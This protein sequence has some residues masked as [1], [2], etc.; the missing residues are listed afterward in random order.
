MKKHQLNSTEIKQLL[1]TEKVGRLATLNSD[2][3]PYVVPVHFAFYND[4]IYIHGLPKGQKVENLKSNPHVC[5]EVDHMSGLIMH[6]DPCHVNT[7]YQSVVIMG[8]AKLIEEE[9][10]IILNQI[11]NKYTPTLSGKKLPAK[12]INVTS[13]IEIKIKECTGKYYEKTGAVS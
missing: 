6:E 9:K 1:W 12:M 7:A 11:V 5:F 3:F 4:K 8:L 10:E 13:V 2:G